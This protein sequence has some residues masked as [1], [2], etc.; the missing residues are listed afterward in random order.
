MQDLHREAAHPKPHQEGVCLPPTNVEPL[1]KLSCYSYETTACMGS[2][3]VSLGRVGFGGS[4]Q[5]G[6]R[7]HVC[8]CVQ[9]ANQVKHLY[10]Y[11]HDYTDYVRSNRFAASADVS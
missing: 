1:H 3:H 4:E 7:P 9:M 6:F 5:E 2:V 8:R 11:G 10:V